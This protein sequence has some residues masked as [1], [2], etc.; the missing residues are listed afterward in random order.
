MLST[1]E[2]WVLI[3]FLLFLVL[4]G[5]RGLAALNQLVG[6]HRQKITQ[7]L[8]EAQHLHDEA[9]SLLKSYKDKHAEALEQAEKLMDLA[10]KDAA[11]FKKSSEEEFTKLLAHKEKALLERIALETEE[12]KSKLRAQAA[13][14]AFAIVEKHLSKDAKVRKMLTAASLKEIEG[15]G[16][17]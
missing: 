12:T 6:D 11:E 9:L 3:A 10:K 2:F 15:M 5:K 8:E 7:Q 14:E 17:F 16:P 1:P 13:E 4:F